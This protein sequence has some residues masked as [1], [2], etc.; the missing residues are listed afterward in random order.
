MDSRLSSGLVSSSNGFRGGR[1]I[2]VDS[3]GERPSLLEGEAVLVLAEQLLRLHVAQRP[4]LREQIVE[5]LD[6]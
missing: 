4:G 1:A 5:V 3:P 6:P 2:E